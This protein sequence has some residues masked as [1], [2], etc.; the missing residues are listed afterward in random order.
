MADFH[1]EDDKT[2]ISDS[3]GNT[4]IADTD[5]VGMMPGEFDGR[6]GTR[7]VLEGLNPC[8]Q[9]T[10]DWPVHVSEYSSGRLGVLNEIGH[11]QSPSS[12]LRRAWEMVRSLPER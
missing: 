12:R 1:D 10:L 3:V 8:Q 11:D 4:V 2:R 5:S 9:A 7:V 6:G